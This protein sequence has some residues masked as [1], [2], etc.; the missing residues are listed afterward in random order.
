MEA[1][2][3][4]LR[5]SDRAGSFPL[6]GASASV[7]DLIVLVAGALLVLVVSIRFDVFNRIIGWVYR[8]DTLQLDE[9]F[10]V[11][12]YL[13]VAVSIYAWRR[14]TEALRNVAL[15]RQAEEEK[16]VLLP[17]LE[18]ALSDVSAL[19]MLLP[20]CSSCKRIR[21]SHGHWYYVEVYIESHLPAKIDGGLCP[22]C[23]REKYVGSGTLSHT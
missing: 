14:H 17:E 7:K 3:R 10:T 12:V 8:H 20:M 2:S 5:L 22:D 21:D 19:R 9:L 13:V 16:A 23:A 18:R 1:R 15:R 6:A 11:A 4:K